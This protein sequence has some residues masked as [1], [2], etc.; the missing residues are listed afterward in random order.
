M[1]AE[2]DSVAASHPQEA[3]VT[4]FDVVNY[5]SHGVSK[6]G[7][8]P[9]AGERGGASRGDEEAPTERA[10][11]I[12]SPPTA[13][14][15]NQKAARGLHRSA[16]R[17][18]K[19]GRARDPDPR[20]PPQEQPALHR[21]R[22]RRQ[23]RHRRG[24]RPAHRR[25]EG[26]RSAR[27]ARDIYALDM[28]SLFAGTKFRGDFE[29]RFKAVI[30]GARG[31]AGN[32][33]ALHRRAAHRRSARARPRAARMDASNLLKPALSSGKLRCIGATT[34]QEYRT[35]IERDRALARRFQKIEVGEPSASPRRRSS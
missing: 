3:G 23:D 2:A 24:H 32:A 7:E 6:A 34:F 15:S 31:E 17:P 19:R 14:I 9:A 30:N 21:R 4:R 11:R 5:I 27:Q 33:I 25:E 16:D 35:H 28:G 8:Q 12:R 13:S 18:R 22:R 29:E 10:R 20:A 26:A 1:F